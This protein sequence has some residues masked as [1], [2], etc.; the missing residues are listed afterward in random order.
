MDHSEGYT[1]HAF[2]EFYDFVVPY[3]DRRDI[4]FFVELARQAEGPTLE[5]GCGTGR[6][7]IPIARA[8]VEIVGLDI[9]APMLAVCRK[10][11]SRDTADVQA[12]VQLAH[13]DMR[14]LA[15]G[16]EF[17]LVTMPFGLF[18]TC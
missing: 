16:Q 13:A 9:S 10:K 6:V 2:A 4:A 14:K 15:L 1:E 8:G 3:R 7:L 5:L 11:L 17:R 12:R 18:S